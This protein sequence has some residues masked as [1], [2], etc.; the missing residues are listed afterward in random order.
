MVGKV[1]KEVVEAG[2]KKSKK[3]ADENLVAFIEDSQAKPYAEA[4]EEAKDL[5]FIHNT[6]E[7]AIRRYQEI[8]GL[9]MPSIGVTKTDVPFDSFGDI[10][11]IGRPEQ[12]DPKKAVNKVYS[13]DAYT[14]RAPS[15]VR[16]AYKKG[17]NKLTEEFGEIAKEVD[18]YMDNQRQ[19][20]GELETKKGL[21]E[22]DYRQATEF[23][24]RN[25]ITD[26]AF[27][28]DIGVDIPKKDGKVD[29]YAMSDLIRTKYKKQRQE[30]A[31]EKI[32]EY[33]EPEKYFISNPDRDYYT[34]PP[35]LKSYTADEI[36]KFMKKQGGAGA[37]RTMT[38]GA[39]KIRATS[40]KLFKSLDEI[41]KNKGLLKDSEYIAEVKQTSDMMLD[42]LTDALEPYYK[43]AATGWQYRDEFGEMMLMAERSGFNRAFKEIGFEDVPESL[44]KEL[45]EYKDFLRE[46][47]TEYFESK[48][49]RV[50]DMSEF[51]GAL[52]PEGTADD[53][54]QHLKKQGMK[55]QTYTDE[56]DRLAKRKS[57]QEYAFVAAGLAVGAST[58][59]E[60][61]AEEDITT[62]FMENAEK[63]QAEA[64]DAW[65][66]S[67]GGEEPEIE[68]EPEVTNWI[69]AAGEEGKE[70]FTAAASGISEGINEMADLTEEIG[71][72][73]N[74]NVADLG[75]L[76]DY[77]IGEATDEQ[78]RIPVLETSGEVGDEI[79]KTIFQFGAGWV[80]GGKALKGVKFFSNMKRGGQ[81][82][83]AMAQGAIADFAAFDPLEERLSN[84]AN[85]YGFGN[86]FTE[87][88]AADKENDT[89]L[90]GRLK[91]AIEGGVIGGAVDTVLS[92][93]KL[94]KAAK[95]VKA[96]KEL[97][98]QK[99]KESGATPGQ[100]SQANADIDMMLAQE[101]PATK[102]NDM[103]GSGD[104]VIEIEDITDEQLAKYGEDIGELP[105]KAVNINLSRIES[106]EDV[107]E[108]LVKTANALSGDIDEA[109]RGEISLKET[110]KLADDMG[111]TV[112]QLLSRKQGEA[113]NAETAVAARKILASSAARLSELSKIA[114]GP[115]GSQNALVAFR[116]ALAV[117][118]AIQK[119]VSGMTAEAGRALS[120]FRIRAATGDVQLDTQ[121][122]RDAIEAS[123]GDE[124]LRDMA[125]K[126]M[127]APAGMI[128][129]TARELAKPGMKDMFF[130]IWINGLL[131]SPATHVVNAVSNTLTS[132]WMIPEK[133]VASGIS[134]ARGAHNIP[135]GEG[136]HQ[137]YGFVHGIRDGLSLAWDS[138][139]S[140]EPSDQISKMEVAEHKAVT[141]ENIGIENKT[142]AKGVDLMGEWV[143]RLPGRM[144]ITADELFKAVGYRMELQ[145]RAYRT[146]VNEGL[147]GDKAAERIQDI[148]NN[149]PADLK[150]DAM[151]MARY[152]T[153]QKE[154]GEYGQTVQK[155]ANAPVGW[156]GDMPLGKLVM[157]FVRTPINI[158]KF[159]GERTPLGLMSKGLRE[160]LAKGGAKADLAMARIGLGT[161]VMG[162]TAALVQEGVITGSGPMNPSVNKSWRENGNQPYSIKMG[163][164][165]HSYSRLDPFGMMLGLTADATAIM[166]YA[167]GSEDATV[168]QTAKAV[169]L[170]TVNNL[171]SKT[172]LSGI[173]DLFKT[174][175]YAQTNPDKANNA[176]DKYSMRLAASFL[177]Y[178]SAVAQV[179]RTLDPALREADGIVEYVK[180][181][182]P[183]LS[184]DLPP[185][186]N[187]FGEPIVLEGGLG[188]DFV[189]PIYTS[190]PK[191][192]PV[193]NEITENK[194]SIARPRR[195]I[196]GVELNTEQYDRYVLLM[197][198]RNEDGSPSPGRRKTLKQSLEKVINSSGYKKATIGP[199]GS[200]ALYIQETIDGYKRYAQ[201]R[202]FQ[203]YPELQTKLNEINEKRKVNLRGY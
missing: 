116:Q 118:G 3:A 175:G 29:G 171:T 75:T 31:S 71:D 114:A 99:L 79:V 72:W 160:D 106:P 74:E 91:N 57:M 138:F 162:A 84:L 119:Q 183:G 176:A 68:Q 157:P 47:P 136:V 104:D 96:E 94:F 146:A 45:T 65:L 19:I 161:A 144:L 180:S 7:D 179:E 59:E 125:N 139:K 130:E 181:R 56:A 6:S 195:Q 50:V 12:F 42:D 122:I 142:I 16:K 164:K 132:A 100:I 191:D 95:K 92:G 15:P 140:G 66:A 39:A 108:A 185:R 186:R 83:K 5:H 145:A 115:E 172:Y 153:Y 93:L 67:Y 11:L 168:G 37:E 77:G 177:P 64:D 148:L 51:G 193:Y 203:E 163:D 28:K 70:F 1:V 27:L 120:S 199:E 73:L 26:A 192:D 97:I 34:T 80:A 20:I 101:T 184:T 111:L 128:N 61:Y 18:G 109:R 167:E 4:V 158:V 40:A 147:S 86:E 170:A 58:T 182:I 117:H 13:A 82:A 22:S 89:P 17:Y 154:L 187:L 156:A 54:V 178:T 60:A 102:V 48:P 194:V 9:P 126:L 107:Q 196:N 38:V 174:L 44:V 63:A 110:E 2:L 10:S 62:S 87:W 202:L 46:A 113:F 198:G 152:V 52:V 41:R 88:L 134:A 90:E 49:N 143:V 85:E 127:D 131:S 112:K 43:Y 159:V 98:N 8:G 155:M 81:F 149:T 30:W 133:F 121:A 14:A 190:T 36:V 173:S 188:W 123:G 151:D 55:V 33:F 78:P 141:A 69:E 150:A 200:K 166:Q 35:R 201:A 135:M 129:R 124:R 189:S 197:A 25:V 165:W 103:L 137:M 32:D 24:E 76:S 21:S 53:V 169:A 105:E 23:F